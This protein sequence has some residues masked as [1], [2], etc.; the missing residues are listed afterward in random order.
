MHALSLTLAAAAISLA[1]I[2]SAGAAPIEAPVEKSGG[3]YHK[4]VCPK[5]TGA[6]VMRCHSLV[7]TDSKGNAIETPAPSP[8][9][10]PNG[11]QTNP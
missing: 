8:R 3:T 1:S 7:V 10:L 4:P 6:Q 11:K 9:P 2:Q 5:T